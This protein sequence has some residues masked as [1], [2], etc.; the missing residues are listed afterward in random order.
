MI[1][2]SRELANIHFPFVFSLSLSSNPQVQYNIAIDIDINTQRGQSVNSSTNN[3]KESLAHSS[4]FSIAYTNRVQAFNNSLSWAD[5]VKNS[6]SHKITLSYANLEVEESNQAN[7]ATATT[8]MPESY[9]ASANNRDM[10][11][12]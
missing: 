4:V 2:L 3:S 5:Q 12:C 8:T 11:M 10:N 7:K 9:E 6:K 1:V